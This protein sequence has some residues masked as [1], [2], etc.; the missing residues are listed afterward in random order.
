MNPPLELEYTAFCRVPDRVR[1]YDPATGTFHVHF[2]EP[3]IGL[4]SA[5]TVKKVTRAGAPT[6]F[7]LTGIPES[8][9][10]PPMFSVGE[11]R[12]LLD[13]AAH[14]RTLFRISKEGGALIV[15]FTAKGRALLVPG[16]RV[17]F[18]EVSW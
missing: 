12:Y 3:L 10:N 4:S 2:T 14:D 9:E 16:V 11:R 5:F 18:R 1:A 15:R 6:V 13:P 8:P 7:R 17:S